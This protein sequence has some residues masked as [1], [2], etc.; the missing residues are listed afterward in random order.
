MNTKALLNEGLGGEEK[1]KRK[2]S[3]KEQ[4][5]LKEVGEGGGENGVEQEKNIET[6]RA[7]GKG[8]T[9]AH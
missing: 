2:K 9:Q 7:W 8:Y 4:N 5:L 1:K 3:Y 6:G